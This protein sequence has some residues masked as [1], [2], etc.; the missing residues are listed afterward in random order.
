MLIFK[1]IVA[2]YKPEGDLQEYKHRLNNYDD[3]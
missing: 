2:K 3:I 1:T